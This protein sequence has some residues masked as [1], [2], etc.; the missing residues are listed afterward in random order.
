MSSIADMIRNSVNNA[1]KQPAAKTPE[2]LEAE[3]QLLMQKYIDE[4]IAR[5]NSKNNQ[6]KRRNK[7][8]TL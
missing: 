3:R 2:E 4:D 1:P 8:N 6:P 5:R 7:E